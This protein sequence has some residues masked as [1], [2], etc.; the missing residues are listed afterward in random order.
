MIGEAITIGSFKNPFLGGESN[1]EHKH[2]RHEQYGLTIFPER[3]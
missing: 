1:M 2:E 3:E